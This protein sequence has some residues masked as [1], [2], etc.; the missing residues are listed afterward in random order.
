MLEGQGPWKPSTK[1]GRKSERP[2]SID[3]DRAAQGMP[4][5][6]NG[7]NIKTTLKFFGAAEI[8]RLTR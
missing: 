5:S 4:Y 1:A 8:C 6:D 7:A 3:L 2:A